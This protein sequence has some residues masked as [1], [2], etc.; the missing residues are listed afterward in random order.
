MKLRPKSLS[1]C[2]YYISSINLQNLFGCAIEKIHQEYRQIGITYIGKIENYLNVTKNRRYYRGQRIE[3][4]DRLQLKIADN[5]CN[6]CYIFQFR[7]AHIIVQGANKISYD[8]LSNL[9]SY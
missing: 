1:N 2:L 3:A 8:S 9:K 5:Q 4:S 7:F 6:F